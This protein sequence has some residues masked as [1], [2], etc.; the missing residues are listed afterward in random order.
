[1][2]LIERIQD[3]TQ[4]IEHI[5]DYLDGL[6]HLDRL[7]ETRTL[8]RKHQRLLFDKAVDAA[9]LTIDYFVPDTVADKAP[10]I[11]EGWNTLPLP[12]GIRTFQKRFCRPGD[13]KSRLFGYNHASSMRIIGPGYFV[14]VPTSG[15]AEWE[16]RGA[17][18]I[19]YFQTPD[20]EVSEGWPSVIPNSKGLQRFVYYQTRDFMRR[21]SKHVTVGAAYKV[22]KSLGQYFM[23]CREAD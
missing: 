18:V 22:E 4:T 7:I 1:M 10:V 6:N 12:Q 21:V 13:D 15:N 14:A 9:P 11:H 20:G 2:K 23:L 19:D 5:G 16:A 3:E 17:I 8:S